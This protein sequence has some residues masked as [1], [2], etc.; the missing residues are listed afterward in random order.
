MTVRDRI[1]AQSKRVAEYMKKPEKYQV[2]WDCPHCGNSHTWWWEDEF[3]AFHEGECHMV[4][5]RCDE[6]VKCV[7][8]GLGFYVAIKEKAPAPGTLGDQLEKLERQVKD[9]Y[10]GLNALTKR[11]ADVETGEIF[12]NLSRRMTTAELAIANLEEGVNAPAY[13]GQKRG[14]DPLGDLIDDA[15]EKQPNILDLIHGVKPPFHERF[16]KECH[17]DG[18]SGETIAR[19]LR[20]VAVE[21]VNMTERDMGG[22]FTISN[23]KVSERLRQLADE[24]AAEDFVAPEEA[25]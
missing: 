5:D 16:R 12:D 25:W 3:E 1:R 10:D 18:M 13:A 11:V 4:C 23:L 22:S 19:I 7:G 14:K 9:L 15:F 21:I 20:F 17:L 6:R 24:A 8:D 2:L